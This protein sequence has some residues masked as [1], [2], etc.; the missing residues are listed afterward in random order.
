[1]LSLLQDIA[2]ALTY[3]PTLSLC[4]LACGG[5]CLLLRRRALA[6]PI[7]AF[8]VAWSLTWSIPQASDWLRGGL[9]SRHPV[10]AETS[11]PEADAIVVLGGGHIGWMHRRDV[12]PEQLRSSRLAAGV[13]AWQ[14]GRAPI[15][16]LSGSGNET[17][18]M[19]TAIAKLEVP[20]S[21]VM[22]DDRSGS[23]RDNAWFTAAL[24]E[25]HGIERIL[26]VTSALHMP[27][28]LRA[29]RDAGLEAVPVP[30]PEI[31]PRADWHE[32]WLPSRRA[33]WRSSRALKE[34]LA[35]AALHLQD[36]RPPPR[37]PSRGV[38][39]A[40]SGANAD[41]RERR[42]PAGNV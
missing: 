15:V 18:D 36:G 21:A 37:P 7:V 13:R 33:L 11:L 9:E 22:L 1:M 6:I 42:P 3:P 5:L 41:F 23:T 14:A 12:R 2:L 35:L 19:A 17:A 31:S 40:E 28:A 26:L 32:R 38:D 25:R 16:I 34:Y 10:V 8:A 24:A 30:V 27:R 4:L 20:A 39:T 29:F